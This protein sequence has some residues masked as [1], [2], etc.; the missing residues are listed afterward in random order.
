M[1]NHSSGYDTRTL[2]TSIGVRVV[3]GYGLS[4]AATS[5]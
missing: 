1:A 4:E 2:P 3:L 5:T